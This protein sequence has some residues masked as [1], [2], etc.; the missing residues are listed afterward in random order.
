M[1][2][3]DHRGHWGN[4]FVANIFYTALH[5]RGKSVSWTY[6]QKTGRNNTTKTGL[7]LH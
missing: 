1:L 5:F 2:P 6:K 3:L 7:L 4:I